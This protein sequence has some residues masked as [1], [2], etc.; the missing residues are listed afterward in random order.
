MEEYT[1]KNPFRDVQS[2]SSAKRLKIA[3]WIS[4]TIS[5]EGRP[6]TSIT[7]DVVER[8]NEIIQTNRRRVTVD[9]IA[10]ILRI[11]FGSANEIIIEYFEYRKVCARRVHV[12][13]RLYA[14]VEFSSDYENEGNVFLDKIATDDETAWIPI[15]Y[16]VI[17]V[18]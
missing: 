3:V 6:F 13:R 8:V 15:C 18:C 16:L 2:E 9:G 1:V 10:E 14:S 11:S 4:L 7:T 5:R 12:N 17:F